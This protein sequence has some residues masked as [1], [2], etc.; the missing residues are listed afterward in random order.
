MI[1]EKIFPASY[2]HVV[3]V[4][5]GINP[6]T[7][8]RAK[9]II[10]L[11]FKD[12]DL[13]EDKEAFSRSALTRTGSP[14]EPAFSLANPGLRYTVCPAPKSVSFKDCLMYTVNL[15]SS[16]GVRIPTNEQLNRFKQ[17]Q[18]QGVLKYGTQIGVRHTSDKDS[19]K[20][21]I[22]VPAEGAELAEQFAQEFLDNP[23]VLNVPQRKYEDRAPELL[24]YINQ[25]QKIKI[26][27]ELP[28]EIWGFSYSKTTNNDYIF[29]LYTFSNTLFG[30]D[31]VAQETIKKMGKIHGWDLSGYLAMSESL[32][33]TKRSIAYHGIFGFVLV[34]SLPIMP[35]IGLAPI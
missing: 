29:S 17:I 15:L 27:H 4:W 24:D 33:H 26:R 3:N 25:T 13:K 30:P 22:E 11:L 31:N 8:Q 12:L 5:S 35:W 23:A 19:F 10:P 34:P 7:A 14:F 18:Q 1:Q 6:I 20:L 16:L 2:N 21:Y 9:N 32:Q 28:G